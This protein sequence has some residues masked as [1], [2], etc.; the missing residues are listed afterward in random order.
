MIYF[1]HRGASAETV[2]NTVPAFARAREFGASHYELDVHLTKDGVLAVHHDYSL[3][4]AAGQEVRI[5]DVTFAGLQTYPLN[6]PFGSDAAFVPRLTDILPVVAPGLACLNIELKNDD[7]RYPGIEENLLD[8]LHAQYPQ[9]LPK[10]L[11]SSFDY[12]TLARLR[13]LD[14]NARLGLLTR[15]F[16]VSAALA[17]GAQSVHLN[18]TRFTPEIARICHENDLRVY[19]YTVNE[20]ALSARLEEEGADGIFTDRIGMFLTIKNP[21]L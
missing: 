2:Q 20:A 5:K 6:N 13:L 11:F 7:N 4:S 12:E 18:Y 17:L 8:L 15:S 19:L 14:R 16:D 3:V 21:A 1:A 9:M 10:I